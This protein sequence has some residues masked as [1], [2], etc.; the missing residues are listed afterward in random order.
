M[1][2]LSW[3]FRE[4]RLGEVLSTTPCFESRMTKPGGRKGYQTGSA[5]WTT[6]AL[7]E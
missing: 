3:A 2:P 5:S 4:S 7:S 6:A 1:V